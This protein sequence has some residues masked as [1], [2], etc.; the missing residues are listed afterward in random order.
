VHAVIFGQRDDL[1]EEAHDRLAKFPERYY[2]KVYGENDGGGT[3]VLYL[4]KIPFEKLGLP[5]LGDEPV[6]HLSTTLQ[7]ALYK[8]FIA[9]VTLYALLGVV[10]WRNRSAN[11]KLD[12]FDPIDPIDQFERFEEIEL[13]EQVDREERTD[14]IKP[15]GW[16]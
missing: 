15:K 16:K 13:A 10:I 9:P 11:A 1:L 12:P 3:S 6:P 2:Q 7:R 5:D 14:R 4:S 8:S